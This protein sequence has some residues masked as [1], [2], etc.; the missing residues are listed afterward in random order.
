MVSIVIGCGNV[1]FET[2]K[3]LSAEGSTVYVLNRS[4]PQYLEE[5]IGSGRSDIRYMPVDIGKEDTVREAFDHILS[6]GVQADVLVV[7]AGVK[8]TES[9][10]EELEVFSQKL[11]LNYIG[12]LFPVEYGIVG[13]LLKNDAHIVVVSSTS[14]HFC[15][16]GLIAYTPSKWALECA[17]YALRETVSQTINA[18]APRTIQNRYSAAF[19]TKHGVEPE[20]VAE[21]VIRALRGPNRPTFFVPAFYRVYGLIERRFPEAFNLAF[22]LKSRF[23]RRKR[24]RSLPAKR[25]AVIGCHTAIGEALLRARSEEP[26]AEVYGYTDC[27]DAANRWESGTDIIFNCC[28]P[29]TIPAADSFTDACRANMDLYMRRFSAL[30]TSL[31]QNGLPKRIINVY[32]GADSGDADNKAAYTAATTALWAFSRGMRRKKGN[33]MQIGEVILSADALREP[34]RSA[35]KIWKSAL[36]GEDVIRL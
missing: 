18:V 17:V 6:E 33:A 19:T 35:D 22:H 14:A 25:A 36:A 7:A 34:Q 12:N 11:M 9:C 16:S 15:R 27:A 2:V 32:C 31:N 13:G 20:A 21:V 10:L 28:E 8:A 26:E 30:L 3:K 4:C 23:L 29:G 5:L 1:G 24:Y